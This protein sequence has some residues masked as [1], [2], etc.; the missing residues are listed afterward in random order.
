MSKAV[1][2]EPLTNAPP[3]PCYRWLTLPKLRLGGEDGGD[4]REVSEFS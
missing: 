1:N 2:V 4:Q 3:Q